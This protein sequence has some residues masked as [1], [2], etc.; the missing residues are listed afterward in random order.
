MIKTKKIC[1]GPD[2]EENEKCFYCGANLDYCC[3]DPDR[4][5]EGGDEDDEDDEDGEG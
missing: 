3:C 1:G 4:Y 2:A 5:L